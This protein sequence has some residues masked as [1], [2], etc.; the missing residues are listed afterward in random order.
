MALLGI[1]QF[2][3][4]RLKLIAAPVA[5]FDA[6]L[7]TCIDNLFETLYEAHGVGLAAIQVDIQQQIIV[8]DVSNAQNEPLC[9]INP[10]ILNKRGSTTHEEG[11]LSFPGVYTKITRAS[12]VD[13]E[14]LDR[15][16]KS[17]T[18]SATGLLATCIQH[19]CDHLQGM[20]YYDLLSPLKQELLRKKLTKY[21]QRTL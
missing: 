5:T 7:Q 16:G 12:E 9:L 3:D 21:R 2:P 11:C 4:P 17:Q 20:T 13:V 8:I 14:F 1:L 19:E 15:F 6:A 18:L 10:K